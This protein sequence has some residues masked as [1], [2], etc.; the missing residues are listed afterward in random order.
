LAQIQEARPPAVAAETN[1]RVGVGLLDRLMDLVGELVLSRNQI[2][3][4][5]VQQDDPALLGTMQRLNVVTS[6][7][8]EGV[9]KTRMQP[10]SRLFDKVPRLV[11]D[12]SLSCG[13][14]ARVE[15][16]GK[17][18]ELDRTLIEAINDPLT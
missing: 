7:L 13:K 8:R 11:R 18:T 12:V 6:E 4:F 5:A 15:S 10:I 1:I 14:Q 17:D 2:M 16:E 9:M 3:K